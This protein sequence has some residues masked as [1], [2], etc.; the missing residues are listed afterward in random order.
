MIHEN[1]YFYTGI[2]ATPSEERVMQEAFR[3]PYIIIGNSLPTPPQQIVHQYAIQH[4]LPEIHG[5]Y[6]YDFNE[7]Q[8]IREAD[9]LEQEPDSWPTRRMP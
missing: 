3:T 8:F 6:G 1:G 9:A 4:D 7:H 5:Y 2:S